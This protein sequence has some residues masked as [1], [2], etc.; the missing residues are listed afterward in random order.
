MDAGKWCQL[1]GKGWK[2]IGTI[3][4][5]IELVQSINRRSKG[6]VSLDKKSEKIMDV[7]RF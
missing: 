3:V 4:E 2:N 5:F 6:L 7:L 1:K